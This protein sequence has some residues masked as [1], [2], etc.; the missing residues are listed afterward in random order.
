M[1]KRIILVIAIALLMAGTTWASDIV[2][3]P[4]LNN[5]GDSVNLAFNATGTLGITTQGFT[6]ATPPG[7]GVTPGALGEINT[8]YAGGT[9]QGTYLTSVSNYGILGTYVNANANGGGGAAFVMTDHQIF[10]AMSGNHHNGITGDF[11]ASASGGMS[12]ADYL[13]SPDAAINMKSIGSMYVW[14][15]A[16]NPGGQ[17][18]LQ[19]N[20]IEKRVWTT[21]DGTLKTDLGLGVNTDGLATMSNSNIWGW[22]NG[23]TG[24][25]STN[26]GGGTRNV[27]ATGTGT[28][29]QNAWGANGW[30]YT[31]SYTSGGGGGGGGGVWNFTG[32]ITGTYSMSAN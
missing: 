24:T 28:L 27:S 6:S 2:L 10:D 31:A 1:S 15:E 13:A 5:P 12:G 32:G 11:F 16:T 7:S 26:Y 9:F 25:S 14:S 3:S 29:V 23:D 21:Q 8:L 22:G 17:P 19:G 4:N 30:T 20:Y 18:P